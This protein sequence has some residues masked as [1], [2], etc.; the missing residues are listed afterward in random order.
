[1]PWPTPRHWQWRSV[2][3]TIVWV[4]R[5]FQFPIVNFP[6]V[7]SNIPA[8][9]ALSFSSCIVCPWIY[10]FWLQINTREYHR[11]NQK[12]TIQRNLQHPAHNTRQTKQKQH[13]M[14]WKTPQQT[15]ICLS[16]WPLYCLSVFDLRLL[17]I[18]LVSSNFSWTK[19][20]S[21]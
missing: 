6:F 5:W 1:M 19:S 2:K 18:S 21:K 14:R 16:F 7:C 15:Q 3:N 17:I 10:G 4:K 8:A 20:F 12:W 13:N 11:C 9:P